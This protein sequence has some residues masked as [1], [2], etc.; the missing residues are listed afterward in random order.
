MFRVTQPIILVF[1]LLIFYVNDAKASEVVDCFNC[2]YSEKS[3]KAKR[4][5]SNDNDII[6]VVDFSNN[7]ISSFKFETL[8]DDESNFVIGK[9]PV[10]V[11]VPHYLKPAFDEAVNSLKDIEKQY[12]VPADIASS[13]YDFVGNSYLQNRLADFME[14]N[15][16]TVQLYKDITLSFVSALGGRF[17]E[18][19]FPIIWRFPNGATA[20]FK[21]SDVDSSTGTIRLEFIK[22]YD[23]LG[24]LVV[25]NESKLKEKFTFNTR[26]DALDYAAALANV[27]N[28]SFN[29]SFSG[30]NFSSGRVESTFTCTGSGSTKQ[31][32]LYFQ[33]SK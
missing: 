18:I 20:L 13:P 17:T 33:S 5:S 25:E 29:I 6:T 2:S 14:N 28:I 22:G 31:C 3:A 19:G 26:E 21:I 27:S 8:Y 23:E 7:S 10:S 1:I 24:N 9:Y 12:D 30:A 16:S 11:A 4:F 15:F 32:T